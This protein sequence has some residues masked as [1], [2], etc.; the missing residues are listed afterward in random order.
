MLHDQFL[1]TLQSVAKVYLV[2][3]LRDDRLGFPVQDDIRIFVP[4]LHL[5]TE[6]RRKEGKYRYATSDTQLLTN[7]LLAITKWKTQA[8]SGASTIVLYQI[9]DFLDLWRETAQASK[10]L[11]AAARI[12]EDHE[13]LVLALTDRRL[14]A[15]FL[16]GNH[17]FELYQS[18]NYVAWE[19]RYYFPD[20]SV[21]A[22]GILLLHGD[23]FDWVEKLP[24]NLQR[25]FVYLFA[26][27]VS[28]NDYQ[29]GEMRSLISRSHGSKNYKDYLQAATPVPLGALQELSP[30]AEIP[31]EWNVQR[32]GD[33]IKFLDSAQRNCQHANEEFGLNM[34]CVVIGHTHYARIAL[35]ETNAG[36]LF[37]LIDCGAWIENCVNSIGAKMPNAQIAALSAN[38]A[39]IYQLEALEQ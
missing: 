35:R 13:D 38:E 14:K 5:I 15:R 12:E 27:H 8:S 4:D 31:R 3:S 39:R 33:N 34:H 29:L 10:Q 9:G 25:I 32:Q 7:V 26:P 37:A 1:A 2:S 16:L 20:N 23:Y 11:E 30:A 28:A 6:K 21:T 36:E 19:R 22:P 17:D 18:T 24:D